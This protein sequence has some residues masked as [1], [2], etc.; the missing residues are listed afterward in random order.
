MS[1]ITEE[2][3]AKLKALA[4]KISECAAKMEYQQHQ[5]PQYVGILRG[6]DDHRLLLDTHN[7]GL[8]IN[9]DPNFGATTDSAETVFVNVLAIMHAGGF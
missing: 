1:E 4:I 8:V 9:E 5:R 2:Q 7:G 3:Q 6:G